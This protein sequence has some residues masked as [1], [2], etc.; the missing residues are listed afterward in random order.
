MGNQ[1]ILVIGG[2]RTGTSIT[3]RIIQAH[4]GDFPFKVNRHN[5]PERAVRITRDF[6]ERKGMSF[7]DRFYFPKLKKDIRLCEELNDFFKEYRGQPCVI[8]EPIWTIFYNYID[9]IPK[10]YKC[11]FLYRDPEDVIDSLMYHKKMERKEAEKS[12]KWFD[13]NLRNIINNTEDKQMLVF[14]KF[15]KANLI[16]VIENLGIKFQENIFNKYYDDAQIKYYKK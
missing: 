3:T 6:L 14:D 12:V 15:Y 9:L 16:N 13:E 1:A 8:K 4:L 11:V 7:E 10:F 2:P 5:E